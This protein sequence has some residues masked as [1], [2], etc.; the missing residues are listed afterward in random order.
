MERGKRP[1]EEKKGPV[2]SAEQKTAMSRRGQESIEEEDADSN[3]DLARSMGRCQLGDSTIRHSFQEKNQQP[4]SLQEGNGSDNDDSMSERILSDGVAG[5]FPQRTRKESVFVTPV[6]EGQMEQAQMGDFGDRNIQE[7]SNLGSGKAPIDTPFSAKRANSPSLTDRRIT[8][9]SPLKLTRSRGMSESEPSSTSQQEVQRAMQHVV[10][11]L[12]HAEDAQNSF[13]PI[14]DIVSA[15]D[16]KKIEGL[17]NA[18]NDIAFAATALTLVKNEL[19]KLHDDSGISSDQRVTGSSSD[20]GDLCL[21]LRVATTA[22]QKTIE[23]AHAA[24]EA[25]ATDP[26]Y[27]MAINTALDSTRG[28][29]SLAADLLEQAS[30]LIQSQSLT[31]EEP[32]FPS[33]EAREDALGQAINSAKEILKYKRNL[34]ENATN[35]AVTLFGALN[36]AKNQDE[37][38]KAHE[39]VEAMTVMM[40]VAIENAE[41]HLSQLSS[42]SASVPVF[43]NGSLPVFGTLR[44]TTEDTT[45]AIE[46]MKTITSRVDQYRESWPLDVSKISTSIQ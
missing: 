34:I 23:R 36:D 5:F 43:G 9:E 27:G 1:G 44:V 35:P 42:S 15:R 2:F 37:L 6:E 11:I 26:Q 19:E 41:P 31:V 13:F 22:V 30:V 25:L 29:K 46:E 10:I 4:S 14:Y 28:M 12:Q 17:L 40:G 21:K 45:H 16:S 24:A 32:S 38:M 33:L 20:R 3:E 7:V 18:S 39:K 8:F